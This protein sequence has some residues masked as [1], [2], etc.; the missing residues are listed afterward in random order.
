MKRRNLLL[1]GLPAVILPIGLAAL[2]LRPHSPKVPDPVYDRHPISY[3]V[4]PSFWPKIGGDVMTPHP[5]AGSLDTNALPYLIQALKQRDGVVR[6]AYNQ[7]WPHLPGWLGK[8]PADSK[9]YVAAQG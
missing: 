9:I 7:L 4:D 3:W 6:T 2:V 5:A 1:I 8:R